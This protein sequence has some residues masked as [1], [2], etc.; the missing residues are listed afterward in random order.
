MIFARAGRRFIQPRPVTLFGEPIQWVETTRYL[1]VTL[2]KRL[3]WSPH[4]VQVRKKTAQ[5]MGMLVPSWTGRV[6]C[7]S[8]AECC[9]ISS[10]SAPWWVMSAPRGVPLPAPISVGYIWNSSSLFAL[11]LESLVRKL[12]SDTRGS[13]CSVVCRPHQSPDCE[14]RLKVSWCGETPSTANRQILT[15]TQVDTVA[16]RESEG[17]QGPAGQSRPSTSMAKSTKRNAFGAYQPS[18]FRIPWRT[19]SVIFLS[20]KTNARV[21]DR[22]SGQGPHSPIPRRGGFTRAPAKCR[23]CDSARLS[24]EPRQ[25]QTKFIPPTIR[26]VPPRR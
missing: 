14:F 26:K 1:W 24:S 21:Y 13:G 15:L 4:I 19:F 11:L 20:C 5:R 25:Q 8:G 6:I 17:R 7:P 12:K 16:R 18:A 23:F 22:T 3:T 2:D 9:Y 10:S